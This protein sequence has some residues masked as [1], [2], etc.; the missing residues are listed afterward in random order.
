MSRVR[1][2]APAGLLLLASLAAAGCFD[3]VVG[4]PCAAGLQACGDICVDLR[5]SAANCGACGSACA[6]RCVAGACQPSADGGVA[7][8]PV[9]AP[10][11]VSAVDVAADDAPSDRAANETGG[12]LPA[13]TDGPP[14]VVVTCDGGMAVCG[15]L[16]VVLDRDPDHCGSCGNACASGLC[17]GGV[18]QS[19]G[20][21]HLVLIGH[22]FVVN[23]AG[24][25]NLIGNAVLLAAARPIAVL[26]YE[27]AA[28][29]EVIDGA[30]AAIDQVTAAA[31]RAW[32]RTI[33]SAG[34]VPARLA[35]NDVFLVYAQETT[36]DSALMQLGR[37]WSSAL[38]AFLASGKTVVVL[39]G[40]SAQHGGTYQIVKAAGLIAVNARAPVTGQMLTVA[41]PGD[42]VA[43]NVPRNYR[44]EMSSVAFD[45]AETVRV[46]AA[47]G[48]AAVV[49][50]RIY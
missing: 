47:P 38:T 29:R 18:C 37:D 5:S 23:R 1:P 45:T 46:V 4:Y 39:D 10:G 3:A 41:A 28:R 31:G 14:A 7:D 9:D 16:C 32:M 36:G 42:A 48:G 44:A 50:H 8:A 27:G 43:L 40:D 22:D 11:D 12:D 24:M 15:A 17:M 20:A 13:P 35:A 25:N 6:G 21:G 33:A 34:Q 2:V 30:N 26:A 19:S 49:I